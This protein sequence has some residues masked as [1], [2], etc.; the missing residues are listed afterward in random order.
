[1]LYSIISLTTAVYSNRVYLNEG[2]QV[3]AIIYNATVNTVTPLIVAF[4]IY[5]FQ[6]SLELTQTL[7]TLK[8]VF[9]SA[10]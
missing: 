6:F 8:V 3:N 5:S 4:L 1:M 2:P 10:L 9:S 7:R